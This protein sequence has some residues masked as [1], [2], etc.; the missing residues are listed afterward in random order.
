MLLLRVAKTSASTEEQAN[1]AMKAKVYEQMAGQLLE[2]GL[3]LPAIT[4]QRWRGILDALH[5]CSHSS[6][7]HALAHETPMSPRAT[8]MGGSATTGS[9]GQ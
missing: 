6:P 5:A 3:N 4:A 7:M 1:A 2:Q 9:Q 8:L